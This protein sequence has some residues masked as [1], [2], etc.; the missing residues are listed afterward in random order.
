MEAANP[1]RK[2]ATS[3][4][5]FAWMVQPL[6]RPAQFDVWLLLNAKLPTMLSAFRI[7]RDRRVRLPPILTVCR[8]FSH[9]T[10]SK[11]WKSF[12]LVMSG[13]LP[14]AP[15]FRMFWN[16]SCVIADVTSLRLMPGMPTAAAGLVP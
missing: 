10:L 3:K 5:V 15:R 2:L 14:L 11:N 7:S 6:A 13:W 8:P 12:W 4:P 16:A 1:S 9:V